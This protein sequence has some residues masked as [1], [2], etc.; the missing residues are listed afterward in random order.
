MKSQNK[1]IAAMMAATLTVTGCQSVN[2]LFDRKADTVETAEKQMLHIIKKPVK[3]LIKI[4]IATPL[5]H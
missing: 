3:H 4:K 5:K 2:G 1:L